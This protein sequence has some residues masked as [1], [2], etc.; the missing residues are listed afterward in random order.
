LRTI[1]ADL[2]AGKGTAGKLLK[3]EAAYQ[4]LEAVLA[5]LNNTMDRL[6]SGQ[7]T[8]GQLIVNPALY[9]SIERLTTEMQ[10]LVREVRQNP[11][12]Y[13]SIRLGLF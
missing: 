6:N 12:K 9:N 13:L 5:K 1:I 10:T 3:D 8:L 11:K 2:N 4:R 7:G